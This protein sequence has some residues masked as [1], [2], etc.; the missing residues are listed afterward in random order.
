MSYTCLSN[1]AKVGDLIFKVKI[2][3]TS[4]SWHTRRVA[5]KN[6]RYS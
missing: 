2:D 6:K 4:K 1:A 3:S 5:K